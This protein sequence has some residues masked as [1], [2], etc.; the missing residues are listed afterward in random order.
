MEN[1]FCQWCHN[2]KNWLRWLVG[3]VIV[4]LVF[5]AGFASGKF[6]SFH[7][8]TKRSFGHRQFGDYQLNKPNAM[9][10]QWN[11][12]RQTEATPKV[13]NKQPLINTTT[14]NTVNSPTK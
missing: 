14:T 2:P 9:R 12:N 8:F 1:K 11:F 6:S 3:A 4:L 7:H 13:L 5:C 10:G